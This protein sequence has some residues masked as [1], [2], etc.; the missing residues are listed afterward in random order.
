MG[1]TAFSTTEER[2]M[3]APEQLVIS[4]ALHPLK[5]WEQFIDDAYFI[6]K[7]THFGNLFHHIKNLHQNIKLYGGILSYYGGR[8]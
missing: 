1:G 7:R 8:K 4:T 6:L 5:V 3:Q 2:Y